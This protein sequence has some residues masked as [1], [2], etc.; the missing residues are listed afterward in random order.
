MFNNSVSVVKLNMKKLIN[1]YYCLHNKNK[2]RNKKNL[3][4]NNEKCTQ[5]VFLAF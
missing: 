4:K 5:F 1:Y 2:K 3:K